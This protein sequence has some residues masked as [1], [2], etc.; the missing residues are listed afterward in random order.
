M[1][2][3]LKLFK[4]FR[5]R[6]SFQVLEIVAFVNSRFTNVVLKMFC[7][8]TKGATASFFNFCGILFKPA[9]LPLLPNMQKLCL[10]D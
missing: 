7:F 5:P 2:Q 1:T 6:F 9:M 8:Y 10:A 4:L 3:I